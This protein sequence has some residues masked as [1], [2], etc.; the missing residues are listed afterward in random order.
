MP[1]DPPSLHL[2]YTLCKEMVHSQNYFLVPPSPFK[3]AGSVP[4][5][6]TIYQFNLAGIKVSILKLVNIRH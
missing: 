1:P 2:G 5:I 3:N 4:D 6:D